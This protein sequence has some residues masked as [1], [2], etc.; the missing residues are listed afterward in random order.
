LTG[1]VLRYVKV[2]LQLIVVFQKGYVIELSNKPKRQLPDA[3]VLCYRNSVL[4]FKQ[5]TISRTVF[6]PSNELH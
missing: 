1:K 5:F 4:I 6:F 2:R 3:Q